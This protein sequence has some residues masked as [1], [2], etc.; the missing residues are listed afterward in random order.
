MQGIRDRVAVLGMG[1]TRFGELW[2]K[3]AEDLVVDSCFEAIEDAGIEPKD[4]KAGW[5]GTV[6]S[7]MSGQVLTHAL[8]LE[9]IPVSRL[10]NFCATATDAFMNACYAVA[11]GIYDI[12]IASGVEKLKDT[13]FA[14]L[15]AAGGMPSAMVEPPV[16]PP[17]QFALVATR[18]AHH[19][20]LSMEELKTALAKIE[21]K[22]HHNGTLNARAHFRREITVEQVLNAPIIAWP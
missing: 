16:P 19:Y 12:V 15:G 5:F 21:V 11:A 17:V 3:S 2:D 1:C 9:Y 10:E 7:G 8:K 4:I 6:M 18:Y 22:N 20:G 13:G 14:G